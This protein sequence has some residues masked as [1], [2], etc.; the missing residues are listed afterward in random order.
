M[1]LLASAAAVV[2]LS[3]GAQARDK[4]KPELRSALQSERTGS[5]W[6]RFTER[7]NLGAAAAQQDW[8]GR[9][10]A[11]VKELRRSAARSQGDVIGKLRSSGADFDVFWA[12]N[13]VYVKKGTLEL[14]QSLAAE[15]EV[16]SIE[17]DHV[18][19]LPEPT[20]GED[21]AAAAA[22]TV[23]WGIKAIGADRVWADFGARGAGIVI[24]SI[25]SGA[26]YDHP[27]LVN[28]YRGK[29]GDGT[30][31]HDYNWYDPALSCATPSL[32]PCDNTGHGTHTI[33]TMTGDGG[34][35]SRIGVAPGAQWIAAKGC[36]D[37]TCPESA[38]MAS[39]QWMLAPT[40]L[41]G[42]NPRPELRPQVVNNSWGSPNGPIVEPWF[43]D[44]V[45]AW[46]AAGMFP[47][48]ANGNEGPGCNTAGSPGDYRNTYA[49]GAFDVNGAI[50]LFSSRGS[51]E[52]G[53][54]KPN[55]AAPGVNVRSAV[56]GNGYASMNG[57]S[58]ASPHVAGA[59]A[60]LWSAAP[61]L[62][63]DIP[64]TRKLLDQTAVDV[65]DTSCG[66]TAQDNNVW[67]EGKL[68]VLAAVTA[69][70][71]QNIGTLSGKATDARTGKPLAGVKVHVDG[72]LE[73]DLV[74]GI[75]GGYSVRLLAG[76]YKITASM[77]GYVD[78]N[79]DVT[80][81]ADATVPADFVLETAPQ[82]KVHG[83]IRDG[84]GQG[85]PLYAKISVAG[86][87]A[88]PWFTDPQT[89]AYEIVL[90]EGTTY[91]LDV[92]A[93]YPGYQKLSVPVA[94]GGDAA[95]DFTLQI[96]ANRC[97]A[98][99][100]QVNG[101]SENFDGTETP[102]GWTVES[103]TDGGMWV[104]DDPTPLGNRTPGGE[105]NFASVNS[106]LS[107]YQKTQDTYLITPAID[108]SATTEPVIRLKTE[109]FAPSWVRSTATIELSTDG[110]QNW[111]AAWSRAKGTV[112]DTL[113]VPIPQ[114]AGKT[115]VRVRF[116]YTGSFDMWWEIDDV[117][118]GEPTCAP[119]PGGLVVGQVTDRNTG[120]GLGAT[121]V[122]STE[123]RSQAGR[124]RATPEDT[125][126]GD[127]F[128]WAFLPRT[129]ELTATHQKFTAQSKTVQI[130]PGA[131]TKADFSLAAGLAELSTAKLTAGQDL[132][133]TG[134]ATVTVTNKGTAPLR[135][136][137][138]TVS[139]GARALAAT[140]QPPV[141]VRAN[142][143]PSALTPSTEQAPRTDAD[144]TATG[145]EGDWSVL[146]PYPVGIMDP[147][148]GT[149]EG[150]IY[151]VGGFDGAKTVATGYSYDPI[152]E[153]WD[154]IP[155]MQV[156]R[157]RASGAFI[158]GKFYV[159][160]GWDASVKVVGITE[161]YDPA[162][163]QWSVAASPTK[164]L[165]AAG[166][167]VLDGKLYL[168]GGC[169]SGN[170]TLAGDC[171][172][173]DVQI[174][175]PATDTWR[176]AAPY[177]ANVGW[178][179]CGAINGKIYCAGGMNSTAAG[180]VA[181]AY[182][183][184]PVYDHWTPIADLPVGAWA[185]AYSAGAGKL[186]VSG[187]IRG[188][189][190]NGLVTN[191][192]YAY[193][194]ASNAWTALPNT[195]YPLYRA[196]TTCGFTIIG[197]AASGWP[198]MAR[199][200]VLPGYEGCG[201]G[202]GSWLSAKVPSGTLAPGEKATISI[203]FD[204]A[205][206]EQP[207]KRQGQVVVMGDSPYASAGVDVALDVTPPPGWAKVEVSVVAQA[208]DGTKTALPSA[209]LEIGSMARKSD[210]NGR[211]VVWLPVQGKPDVRIIASKD[212]LASAVTTVQVKQG[213]AT[214]ELVLKPAG[215]C[216]AR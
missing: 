161:V 209:Y 120:A 140:G 105:G 111:A 204:T 208:C 153:R 130:T 162:K 77:F 155:Q 87:A 128:Y 101:L 92:Q 98:P 9:G 68:D 13:T 94:F 21:V 134:T 32:V 184:D 39:A 8:N 158:D 50:A 6:V 79:R 82:G 179:S 121:E 37:R 145:Q 65:A 64:A 213:A 38:L 54:I 27:A 141:E 185:S 89:G 33:G 133:T 131:I 5:Y 156:A 95:K 124:S 176:T 195:K 122:A 126:T 51:G 106:E 149:H 78:V 44:V 170:G 211:A 99:G 67:G 70:P 172:R 104:F 129:A 214:A 144:A 146:A 34:E 25:D 123:A 138:G 215:G 74:T 143:T 62:L 109:Y 85:W 203:T 142:V 147:T 210:A 60:L 57:T 207:G 190:T 55:I 63:G 56:P 17:A 71:V 166:T 96:D 139:G 88:G 191:Q 12:S 194:P 173:T 49:A 189:I 97:K 91:P 112:K 193:D 110:G 15:S 1:S 137:S 19:T 76:D 118:V 180:P 81:K 43:K 69:A 127:G 108:L 192:G 178:A 80:I 83:V 102:A 86:L 202:E 196:G 165:A 18:Y 177:P 159:A 186:L 3:S 53:D 175:D 167:V 136:R 26:Q 42:K 132:G 116:H 61:A 93:V 47:M 59:I 164:P 154:S 23:E 168:I 201:T 199:S 157:Q 4:I 30:F 107:G 197:G 151:A 100:Y 135:P 205:K 58:M 117:L 16:T 206:L 48:F 40:D 160:G 29:R 115:D 198:G 152:N 22:D 187:G 125:A 46:I 45:D 72:P 28:S 2:A 188:G 36:T 84:S 113:T 52:D 183:Y 212:G 35:G 174:Y 14:A 7:P 41:N 31:S 200:Q 73:R 169:G 11:V 150:R 90:P 20:R 119:V 24:G 163:R 114:A 103:K 75:D 10:E 182:S 181:S 66:G 171:G 148:V 216:S